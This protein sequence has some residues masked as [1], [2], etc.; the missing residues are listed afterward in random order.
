MPMRRSQIWIE[1]VVRRL[2][3]RAP[4]DDVSVAV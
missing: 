4:R 3:P 2:T 1:Q